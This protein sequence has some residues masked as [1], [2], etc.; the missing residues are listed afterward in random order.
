MDV[1]SLS[2]DECIKE[3]G[4]L[5]TSSSSRPGLAG[6]ERLYSLL[7]AALKHLSYFKSLE[8]NN[9][10][11]MVSIS[12]NSTTL[13]VLED[14]CTLKGIPSLN[15]FSR[16]ILIAIYTKI[17]KSPSVVSAGFVVRSILNSMLNICNNKALDPTCKECAVSI[18][19]VCLEYR[20]GDCG[21][22]VTESVQCLIS[23]MKIS[24]ATS[25]PSLRVSIIR[26][27]KS[28][29]VGGGSKILDVHGDVVKL[30]LK[31]AADRQNPELRQQVGPF[32]DCNLHFFMIFVLY[33]FRRWQY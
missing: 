14:I 12:I 20:F 7:G 10:N 1:I 4:A 27:L 25:V 18:L 17:I 6:N 21:S 8:S 33:S 31:V 5:S 24:S 16:Q 9:N 2:F 19:S 15:S 29:I 11:D 30:L 13:S 26:S 22:Q 23:L 32:V 28:I 3:L